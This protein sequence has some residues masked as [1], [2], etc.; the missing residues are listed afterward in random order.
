MNTREF[1]LTCLK[2]R[3]ELVFLTIS[4][5]DHK[6]PS[7]HSGTVVQPREKPVHSTAPAGVGVINQLGVLMVLS[8]WTL[9]QDPKPI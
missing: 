4:I 9:V 7:I 5:E 6:E 3:I 2:K 1:N 8:I